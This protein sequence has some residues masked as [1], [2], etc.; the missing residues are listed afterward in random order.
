MPFDN[1]RVIPGD[2]SRHHASAA[3]GGM[4][5]TVTIGAPTGEST[6]DAEND[7]TTQGYST[8]YSGPARIQALNDARQRD[9]AGEQISGRAYLVQI[10]FDAARVKPGMR[11]HVT[12]CANDVLLVGEDLWVVDPQYGSE[13]FTRD[14]VASDNQNDAPTEG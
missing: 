10:E 14:L 11:I 5:A 4:N 9:V 1:T 12:A 3:R 13:R 2:W 7:V 6:Y 8:D